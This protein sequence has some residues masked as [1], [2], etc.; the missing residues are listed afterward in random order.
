MFESDNKS[1]IEY[2]L[3]FRKSFKNYLYGGVEN[4]EVPV[5]DKGSFKSLGTYDGYQYGEYCEIT[6]Q[7]M[8]ISSE[9]LIAVIDKYHTRAL[10]T[11]RKN[12][13]RYI[14]YKS[15]FV[16]GKLAILEKVMLKDR[17]VSELPEIDN[18]NLIS[19]G[20]YDGYSY[21]L[22]EYEL[23]GS[24]EREAN[25]PIE[26]ISRECFNKREKSLLE[27]KGQTK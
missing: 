18:E 13:D 8:S 3:A 1:L 4:R 22:N 12:E 19:V 15:G 16:D 26:Q 21:F 10:E 23:N 24:I 27:V 25:I 20:Y 17:N 14:R 6:C 2:T 5:L 9:Q 7:T 11:Y